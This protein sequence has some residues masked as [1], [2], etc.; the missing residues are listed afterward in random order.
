ERVLRDSSVA[1][2]REAGY[3]GAG[4]C[5]FLVATDGTIS[6]LEVNTRLQVEHPVTE[7]VTGIDLVREQL[8]I[9]AGEPLGYDEV[10][11]RGHSIECRITGEDPGGGFLT[12]PGRITRLVLPGGPVVRI[13][14]G[15]V[16]GDSVSG[17][18]D[19]M[20]AELVV[21][22]ATRSQAV[23]R[24]RRALAELEVG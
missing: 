13:D 2:L 4:T 12:A 19:S 6:F 8:R 21:T 18:F 1:I 7:E 5:E 23:Q 16:E 17:A 9:A 10:A 15:V 3:V 22:G 14:S 24:A 11:V 20:I